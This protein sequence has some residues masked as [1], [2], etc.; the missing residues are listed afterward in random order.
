MDY[1]RFLQIEEQRLTLLYLGG[2]VAF[3]QPS[4]QQASRSLRL[5][6]APTLEPG[7]YAATVKGRRAELGAPA[8]AYD[9]TTLPREV[10]HW[11]HGYLA[12]PGGRA[13]RVELLGNAEPELLAPVRARRHETRA[14]LFEESLFES[15][16]EGA[17]RDALERGEGLRELKAMSPALRTAFAIATASREARRL[18]LEIAPSE[19]GQLGSIADGGA[20]AARA[21]LQTILDRRNLELERIARTQQRTTQEELARIAATRAAQRRQSDTNLAPLER[22]ERALAA[23]GAALLSG[24]NLQGGTLEVRYS[25]MGERFVSVVDALTLHVF[26]AGVCLAGADEEVTLE[27]LPSVLREAIEGGELVIT[28]R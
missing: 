16:A 28:R 15:E 4:K 9:L 23:A 17:A 22:A 3:A 21:I 12:L 19:L 5:A 13:E 2:L 25:F 26:D 6:S 1:K 24:R 14:L 10:G 11:A 7:F 18:Q 8:D 27:S 20:V